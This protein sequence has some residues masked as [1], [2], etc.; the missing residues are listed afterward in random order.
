MLPEEL[1]GRLE[2]AFLGSLDLGVV[3]CTVLARPALALHM[4]EENIPNHI[5][6]H[7]HGCTLP[8]TSSRIQV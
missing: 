6:P 5:G 7:S 8:S 2:G 3:L 4:V 1:D